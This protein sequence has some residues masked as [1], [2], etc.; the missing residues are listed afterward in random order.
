M[1]QRAR[2]RRT[3]RLSRLDVVVGVGVRLGVT[4]PL[5]NSQTQFVR[6]H[7]QPLHPLQRYRDVTT[8]FCD[9]AL[10]NTCQLGGERASASTWR[11]TYQCGLRHVSSFTPIL[12]RVPGDVC[13]LRD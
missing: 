8:E 2:E 4:D 6:L 10:D 3:K 7:L 11:T 5:S 9:L 12:T 13:A 1:R